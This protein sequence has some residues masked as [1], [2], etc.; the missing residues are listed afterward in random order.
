VL[1]RYSDKRHAEAETLAAQARRL[2]DF[3]PA[4]PPGALPWRPRE[5]TRHEGLK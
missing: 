4:P 1:A 3:A 2:S 5:Q